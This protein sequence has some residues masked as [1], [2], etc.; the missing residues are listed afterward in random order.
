MP[1]TTTQKREDEVPA[2]DAETSSSRTPVMKGKPSPDKG[3]GEKAQ[4]PKPKKN[5]IAGFATGFSVAMSS[6]RKR[7]GDVYNATS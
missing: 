6:G 7:Q 1:K 5:P 4:G 3:K 2:A